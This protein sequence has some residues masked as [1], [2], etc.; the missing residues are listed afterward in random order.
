MHVRVYYVQLAAGGA[1]TREGKLFCLAA[2]ASCR[3]AI[4]I[5]DCG[6]R[7]AQPQDGTRLLLLLLLVATPD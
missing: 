5:V 2:V 7:R 6:A 4:E 1:G 3:R